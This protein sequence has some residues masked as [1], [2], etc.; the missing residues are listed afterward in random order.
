MGLLLTALYKYPYFTYLLTL[1]LEEFPPPKF[2]RS[3]NVQNLERFLTT[4]DFDHKYLQNRST[5]QLQTPL[6]WTKEIWW[7]LVH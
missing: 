7:T 2:G 4:F 1:I 5:D 3:K 6:Y